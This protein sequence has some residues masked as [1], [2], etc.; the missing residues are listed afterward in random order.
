MTN[1]N[2]FWLNDI[3]KLL[4]SIG[5]FPIKEHSCY[6]QMYSVTKVIIVCSVMVCLYVKY[7]MIFAALSLSILIIFYYIKKNMDKFNVEY[8]ERSKVPTITSINKM[9]KNVVFNSRSVQPGYKQS[10]QTYQIRLNN[11]FDS[12]IPHKTDS[13]RFCGHL[14][15]NA[16]VYHDKNQ[17]NVDNKEDFVNFDDNSRANT[18][19]P[20]YESPGG[21][22]TVPTFNRNLA[23]PA[24]PKTFIQPVIVPKC[25]D[26]E[27]WKTN[28]LVT[29]SAINQD[30]HTDLYASGY[31]V[32]SCQEDSSENRDVANHRNNENSLYYESYSEPIDDFDEIDD[33]DGDKVEIQLDD[34]SG[35]SNTDYGLPSNVSVGSCP[36]SKEFKQYNQNLHTTI[37]TPGVYYRNKFIEPISSNIGIS[38]VPMFNPTT[39]E[40][41]DNSEDV[42]YTEHDY[43]LVD[44]GIGEPDYELTNAVSLDNIYDPRHNGYGTSYRAYTDDQLGQTKFYYDDIDSVKMPNYITRSNIDFANYADS[45]GPKPAGHEQGNPNTRN[46]REMANETFLNCA[47]QHRTDI[48]KSLSRKNSD[49]TWQLRQAPIS[50]AGFGGNCGSMNM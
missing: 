18:S 46:I 33:S 43:D 30:S 21:P 28:N 40:E 16:N 22:G 4:L 48:M 50:T 23:G 39:H 9:N 5:I 31:E 24:N 26:I 2:N 1:L 7:G 38:H 6:Q 36:T 42:M 41:I 12:I 32:T 14:N 37:V 29:H 35:Q 20:S 34:L 49:R 13:N 3:K 25:M 15:T 11:N 45:Y 47:I 27:Y 8:F 19:W 17:H 10:N 44:P